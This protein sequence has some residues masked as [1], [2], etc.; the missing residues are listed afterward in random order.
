M[1]SADKVL[2]VA[3]AWNHLVNICTGSD[4]GILEDF[5]LSLYH[6]SGKLVASTTGPNSTLKVIN[7]TLKTYGEYTIKLKNYGVG[8][9]SGPVQVDIA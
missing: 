7:Y 3:L 8:S 1:T 6:P 4:A 9:V 2:R 5:D